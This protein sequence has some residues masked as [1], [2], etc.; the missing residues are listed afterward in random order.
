MPLDYTAYLQIP[1]QPLRSIKN[2]V[3]RIQTPHGPVIRKRYRSAFAYGHETAQLKRLHTHG[4]CVPRVLHH[5]PDIAFLEDFGDT[6]YV[7]VLDLFKEEAA[8]HAPMRAL[9]DFLF[10]YYG[11]T[12]ALRGDVNLRNFLYRDG[13]CCG[14]DFEEPETNG[15]Y[16]SDMGRIIAFILTY[17]PA[18]NDRR[19]AAAH[20]LWTICQDKGMDA[21]LLWQHMQTEFT[22]MNDRRKGFGPLYEKA[23]CFAPHWE[24][25]DA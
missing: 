14:V 17:A 3:A 12:H 21:A 13:A 2:D 6:T 4:L 5:Q 10:A 24:G 25:L 19:V 9:M 15:P 23:R 1:G 16:E 8:F 7:D 20:A 18:F 22:A 11:I